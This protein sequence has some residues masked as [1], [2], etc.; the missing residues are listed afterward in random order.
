MRGLKSIQWKLVLV[1]ILLVVFALELFG[2]YMLSSIEDYYT[3]N[4]QEGLHNQ[5]QLLASLSE[6]YYSPLPDPEGL[7]QLIWEFGKVIDRDMYLLDKYG[8]VIATSP[9]VEAKLGKR[10]V[11]QEVFSAM[12]GEATDSL[13]YDPDSGQRV[14]Y[15]AQPIYSAGGMVGA[16]Y[17]STSFQHIDATL[18]QLRTI[19]LTG[20]V[21]TLVLSAILGLSLS[22][23]ITRPLKT[24][25]KQAMNMKYGDFQQTIDIHSQDEIGHLGETFNDLAAQLQHSWDELVQE[26]DK[27]EGILTNLSDGLIVF[28]HSGT[29]MHINSTACNWFGKNKQTMLAQGSF[30]DFPELGSDKGIIYLEGNFGLVL[31]QQR[32]PFLQAGKKQGTIIV[33][34]DITEQY[35]LDQ[36]RQEFVANVS[37][38]LRTP[39]TTIKT[40][41]ETLMENPDEDE[42]IRTRFLHVINSEAERMVRMVEDL[43]IISRHENRAR[44]FKRVSIGDIIRDIVRG[45]EVQVANKD[46]SLRVRIPRHLPLVMGDS[47]MLHRLF[48]NIVNNAISYTNTGEISISVFSRNK[49]V[50]VTIRDTGIGIPADAL[51]RIFERFY[52]V[53]K[54]RSRKGGG[55]GLGLSIAKQIAEAHGGTINVNSREGHGTEVTIPLPAALEEAKAVVPTKGGGSNGQV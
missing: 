19:L 38:E 53:D 40:Y 22:S 35:R 12:Q 44:V 54:A 23:A 49:C 50:E 17:A 2:V 31:H 21:L 11:Q 45:V 15:Y 9:G 42:E 43:L 48:L 6:R 37:H 55:T 27:V 4:L 34:S 7:Q 33:L 30:A 10:I 51:G 32:L 18:V 29:V 5:V 28:G 3:G 46:L 52:R 41:L 8:V 26:K 39:L 20:A 24:I 13:R 36:I 14:Y 47:D 16:V 25:T 1:Y